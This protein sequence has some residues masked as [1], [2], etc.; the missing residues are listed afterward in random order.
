MRYA[1]DILLIANSI[2]ELEELL[3]RLKTESINYGLKIN[4]NKSKVMII[5]RENEIQPK[6]PV[7]ANCEV[8]HGFVY[9]ESLLQ[10]TGGCD[11]EIRRRIQLGRTAMSQL[12]KLWKDRKISLETKISLVSSLVFSVF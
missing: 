7:I 1:D 3:N 12:T 2:E 4:Y 5:D 9:L 8:V 11:M 6:P 10:N